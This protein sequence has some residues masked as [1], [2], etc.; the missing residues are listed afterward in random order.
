MKFADNCVS[1]VTRNLRPG[2]WKREL[3]AIVL[4]ATVYFIAGKLGLSLAFVHPSST[5]I[6]PPSGIALAAFLL[7]GYRVWPG[8][9][10]GAFVVNVTT[11]GTVLTSLGIATGNT[12]EGLVAAYLVAK[13]ANGRNA[14]N[15]TSD[16]FK[17]AAACTAAPIVAATIGVCSLS[18]G[19]FASWQEFHSIWLTWW[20]GDAVGAML[21]GSLIILWTSDM[22][23]RWTWTQLVE[24]ITLVACMV[25]VGEVVFCG[26]FIPELRGHPVEY[27]CIPFL[28]WAALRF[29]QKEAI[30]TTMMLS[31][32][33]A[34]GTIRGFGPFASH[35]KNDSL[36][37]LQAF[38]GIVAVMT[39]AL[40]AMSA[41]RRHIEEDVTNLAVTDPLTGLA[42]YRKLVDVLDAEVRRYG[43]AGRPFSVLL[44]DMDELKQINDSYGHLTGSHALCRLS[45][46]LR[47]YC[48]N[49]DTA[50]RY[51]GDEFALVLPETAEEEARQVAL[52][53]CERVRED[54]EDP[55]IS[56]SI[57]T[58]TYPKSGSTIELMLRAADRAMYEMK[59]SRKAAATPLTERESLAASTG[60]D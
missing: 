52:R 48:R 7:L 11:A 47:V 35:D 17:F 53:I 39:L 56:V 6:W 9:L 5:A 16:T 34:W 1:T 22:S 31:G 26:L 50:A 28:L 51:G 29:G 37:L 8:I 36:L 15:R 20:L 57:G 45:D 2:E 25:L 43:R 32:I 27:L 40:A 10:I 24:M 42:N 41:E 44:I 14:F 23:I 3:P 33:A 58:A 46:I 12:L 60:A 13:F 54:A 4:L 19:G 30:S 18:F 38:M 21:V 55:P 59:G 49:I